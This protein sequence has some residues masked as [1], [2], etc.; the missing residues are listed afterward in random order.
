MS[1]PLV[2]DLFAGAGLFSY[3][4]IQEGF[5]IIQ[6]VENDVFAAASYRS[7]LGA[8]VDATNIVEVAPVKSCDVLIAGP[9][10]QGFS[11]LGKRDPNDPRSWLSLELLR[12]VDG[13]NPQVVVVENVAA[14]LSSAAFRAL[15]KELRSR[16]F[17]VCSRVLRALDFGVPQKRERAFVVGV[18][19]KRQFVA[20][21]IAGGYRSLREA[22]RG[23]PAEPN[24]ENLHFSPVPSELALRRMRVLPYGGDK[25]DI[26]RL[27]PSLAAP[28][29]CRYPNAVTDVWGRMRWEEPSNTLRTCF[30]NPSKGRY[31][32][33]EQ[34]RVLTIRE[35][36]RLQ[37][38][39]DTWSFV[40]PR[41]RIV[42]QIG[43][44]VPPLMGRGIARGVRQLL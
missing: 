21:R 14:F 5:E 29:W 30:Q 35:G 6:A 38:I 41:T 12:W 4:F 9:P 39:P 36:A 40:G 7:N 25:R 16:G 23:L 15:A 37:T 28:S 26:L 27:A 19:D 32:H 18:R 31:I 2:V 34:N 10:C 20:P 1:R 24:G 3:A 17:L 44:A 13:A 11:T 22:W 8:V 33:P 42:R 43:N